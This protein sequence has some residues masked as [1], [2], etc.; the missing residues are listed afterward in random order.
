MCDY[1]AP[2]NEAVNREGNCWLEAKALKKRRSK[3]GSYY[4]CYKKYEVSFTLN[5]QILPL[6]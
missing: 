3:D 2:K 5:P 4:R 1:A 6:F